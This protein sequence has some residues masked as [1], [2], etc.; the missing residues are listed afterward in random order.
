VESLERNE[1]ILHRVKEER[2]ILHRIK[3]KKA[4][5]I[6]HVLLR[7]CLLKHIFEATIEVTGRQGR[8]GKQLLD[9]LQEEIGY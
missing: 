7:N 1:E 3:R 5:W 8:K 2:K 9:D 4:N 6:G